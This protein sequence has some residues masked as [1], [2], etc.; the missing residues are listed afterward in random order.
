M[1]QQKNYVKMTRDVIFK[2]FFIDKP[3]IL[4]HF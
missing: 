1:K 2:K 4:K 3:D